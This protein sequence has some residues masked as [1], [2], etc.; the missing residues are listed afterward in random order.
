MTDDGRNRT[1][2][3]QNICRNATRD[4]FGLAVDVTA[5]SNHIVV[6]S[7][8]YWKFDKR[9]GYVQV[10]FLDS[11]DEAGTVR[12]W[13]QAGQDSNQRRIWVCCVYL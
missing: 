11:N 4:V 8:G 9:L 12:A 13:K 6:G 5:E 3:G 10:F 1:Q 7:P 2:L